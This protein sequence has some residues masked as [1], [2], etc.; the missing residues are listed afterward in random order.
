[1]LFTGHPVIR[2]GLELLQPK[3]KDFSFVTNP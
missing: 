2:N 1:M 3:S